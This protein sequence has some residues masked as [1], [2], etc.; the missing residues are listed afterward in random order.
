MLN[1]AFP[2]LEEEMLAQKLS[3]RKLLARTSLKYS[4]MIIKLRTGRNVTVDEGAEIQQALRTDKPVEILFRK[5]RES[6]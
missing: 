3:A 6:A 2:E 4:T 5:S 1:I